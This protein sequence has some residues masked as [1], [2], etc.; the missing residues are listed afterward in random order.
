MLGDQ[1]TPIFQVSFWMYQTEYRCAKKIQKWI[2]GSTFLEQNDDD[3]V[4]RRKFISMCL[5]LLLKKHFFGQS[6]SGNLAKTHPTHGA[7]QVTKSVWN[8]VCKFDIVMLPQPNFFSRKGKMFPLKLFNVNQEKNWT[9]TLVNGNQVFFTN[10]V[11][12]FKN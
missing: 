3:V 1:S 8:H 5:I 2:E 6:H 10:L 9:K 4:L 7:H 12:K 11:L